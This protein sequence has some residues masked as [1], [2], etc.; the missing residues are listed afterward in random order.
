VRLAKNP[1]DPFYIFNDRTTGIKKDTSDRGG[2]LGRNLPPPLWS[3]DPTGLQLSSVELRPHGAPTF[4]RGAEFEVNQRVASTASQRNHYK[5]R[6]FQVPAGGVGRRIRSPRLVNERRR[7][8]ATRHE[9]RAKCGWCVFITAG[10]MIKLC[11]GGEG[12]SEGHV[13]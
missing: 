10:P 2:I 5:R 12:D 6:P 11:A 13:L 4:F 1:V 9:V 8:V 7:D 3:F